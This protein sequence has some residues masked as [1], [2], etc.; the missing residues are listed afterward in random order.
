MSVLL[1]G[2]GKGVDGGASGNTIVSITDDGSGNALV[3][4][5]AAHGLIDGAPYSIDI[6]GNSVSGYNTTHTIAAVEGSV[7]STTTFI[8]DQPYTSTGTGG[9][10][11]LS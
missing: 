9:T 6:T 1:L 2:A 4:T 5:A 10:W 3:T 11:A 7:P 8:T